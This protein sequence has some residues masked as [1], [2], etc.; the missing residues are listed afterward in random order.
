MVIGFIW[1]ELRTHVVWGPNE[2]AGHV[3]LI[4]QHSGDAKVSNFDDVGFCQENI[5][6]FKVPVKNIPLMQILK[7]KNHTLVTLLTISLNF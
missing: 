3:I 2:C 5:L 1:E 4:F 7:N 6:S